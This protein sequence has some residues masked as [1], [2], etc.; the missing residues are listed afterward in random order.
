MET[1]EFKVAHLER[2]LQE[3]SDIVYRQHQQLDAQAS[4]LLQL[5]E[6]FD[7]GGGA[8]TTP[9]FERPPHY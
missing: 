4:R 6:R 5:V 2:A 8:E 9:K 7:A 1:L 3:L